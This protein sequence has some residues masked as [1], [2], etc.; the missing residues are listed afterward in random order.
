MAVAADAPADGNPYHMSN[1]QLYGKNNLNMK[2]KDLRAYVWVVAG[3]RYV[4]ISA[5]FSATK[6]PCSAGHRHTVS[7]IEKIEL[8]ICL[9][10]IKKHAHKSGGINRLPKK[11]K[12]GKSCGA[13]AAAYIVRTSSKSITTRETTKFRMKRRH[14]TSSSLSNR[15]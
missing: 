8:M 12:S 4:L 2:K 9:D 11:G 6:P 3:G 5:T 10:E 15:E 13:A 7:I 1:T 14:L